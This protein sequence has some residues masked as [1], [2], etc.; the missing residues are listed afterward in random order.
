MGARKPYSMHSPVLADTHADAGMVAVGVRLN[1]PANRWQRTGSGIL[2]ELPV[3]DDVCLPLRGQ[4]DV[5]DGIIR[6]PFIARFIL[7]GRVVFPGDAMRREK[8]A[9]RG[10]GK[11]G[12][13]RGNGSVSMELFDS[14]PLWVITPPSCDIYSDSLGV[15]VDVI[16]CCGD[17]EEVI[18]EARPADCIVEVIGQSEGLCVL[19]VIGN[20]RLL[21][22]GVCDIRR[23]S[24]DILNCPT[25]KGEPIH[26]PVV[27]GSFECWIIVSY[28]KRESIW[29]VV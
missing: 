19:P 7:T 6:G 11:T 14:R 22:L 28:V 26:F 12:K 29:L 2:G 1:Q 27:I 4:A 16:V 5:L 21:E 20:V 8:I 13:G 23:N 18:G 24:I 3:I 25:D 9:Q 17:G 10:K 15:G